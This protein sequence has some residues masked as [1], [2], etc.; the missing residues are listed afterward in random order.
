MRKATGS[1]LLLLASVAAACGPSRAA[2]APVWREDATRIYRDHTLHLAWG[3]SLGDW[4]DAEGKPM[5]AKPFAS[6][7]APRPG[8]P[9]TIEIDV[10]RL[11]REHG[12]DFRINTVDGFAKLASREATEGQP[13]LR[14]TKRGRTTKLSASADT[15]MSVSTLKPIGDRP[16]LSTRYGALMRFDQPADAAIERAVLVLTALKRFGG[17]PRLLV[18]RTALVP[19]GQTVASGATYAPPRPDAL[20]TN[21]RAAA[22]LKRAA[23]V[24]APARGARVLFAIDGAK[25][26]PRANNRAVGQSLEA[27]FEGDQKGAVGDIL[28]LPGAVTEAFLTVVLRL[29]ND[30]VAPGGKLPGLSN[31][32]QGHVAP[33]IVRGELMKPGGW[34]GRPANACHWSARTLFRGVRGGEIGSGTYMYAI[35]PRDVNGVVDVWSQPLPKGRWVAYV[36]RVKLNDPGRANGEIGYWLVDRATAPGG[37][38]VQSAGGIVWRDTDQAAS[39]INE[40]WAN[41]FCGGRD[42]GA[43]PWPRSTIFLR[44]MTVTD[45]LPDMAAVQAELDRLNA[46]R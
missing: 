36:E 19:A 41:V 27:W 43:A 26:K 33:C 5:G 38:P 32:G 40:V 3:N 22:V 44:R 17:A 1:A 23:P 21:P 29:G 11:V 24:A 16:A 34:G 7:V 10:T 25:L 6:V 2:D 35:S 31:T 30:W 15:E 45:G 14:V 13:E 4:L 46:A 9:A 12:A 8:P 18:F 39:A 42:C 37:K 20:R 28:P